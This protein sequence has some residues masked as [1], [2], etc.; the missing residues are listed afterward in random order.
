MTIGWD[1]A[2]THS[3]LSIGWGEPVLL[4]PLRPREHTPNTVDLNVRETME[5]S[6]GAYATLTPT[7]TTT[8]DGAQKTFTWV[9]RET[10]Q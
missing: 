3:P 7:I 2:T 10:H 1:G 6:D 5:W 9:A 4:L 8:A